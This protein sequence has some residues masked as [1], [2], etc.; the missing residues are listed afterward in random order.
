LRQVFLS[1]LKRG[2]AQGAERP[3]SGAS[4]VGDQ[5]RRRMTSCRAVLDPVLSSKQFPAGRASE[6]RARAA[7]GTANQL[8]FEQPQGGTPQMSCAT[9]SRGWTPPHLTH[10][11]A[12]RPL[13]SAGQGST[14]RPKCFQPWCGVLLFVFGVTRIVNSGWKIDGSAAALQVI[15]RN[16]SSAQ[17]LRPVRTRQRSTASCRASATT[18]R[19]GS[20][21]AALSRPA[22]LR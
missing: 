18:Q 12:N 22:S 4:A 2:P 5:D 10:G 6:L 21:P 16:P 8:L 19:L 15:S 9:G 7:C 13:C 3:E 14:L 1:F 11:P 20:L 17:L